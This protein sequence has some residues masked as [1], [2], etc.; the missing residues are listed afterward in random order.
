MLSVMLYQDEEKRD[1]FTVHEI[2]DDDTLRN[3][4]DE[5]NV[6]VVSLV[7][8]EEAMLISRKKEKPDEQ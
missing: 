4:T 7:D 8:G 5:F 1:R 3:V 2:V 6:Q